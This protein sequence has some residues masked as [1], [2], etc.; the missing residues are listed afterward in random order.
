MSDLELI[1][2][3]V[4]DIG[5]Q[6]IISVMNREMQEIWHHQDPIDLA[7]A[8]GAPNSV[9]H[10]TLFHLFMDPNNLPEA[11][12]RMNTIAERLGPNFR[13]EVPMQEIELWWN[14]WVFWMPEGLIP[15]CKEWAT[16]RGLVLIGDNELEAMPKLRSR[17]HDLPTDMQA[18]GQMLA[19][20]GSFGYAFCHMPHITLGYVRDEQHFAK[21]PTHSMRRTC[22]LTKLVLAQR[23]PRGTIRN[24]LHEVPLGAGQ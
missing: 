19:D 3:L 15:Q 13:L 10:M 6:H 16:V 23:G 2:A 5:T 11:E 9:A 12:R 4:P 8:L 17:D 20:H 24:I 22:W 1:V 21:F 14:N 7:G 18:T